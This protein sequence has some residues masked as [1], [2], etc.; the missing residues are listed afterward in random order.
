MALFLYKYI[1]S[2][3]SF[4]IS[5]L[6]LLSAC[7]S[8]GPMD[9]QER[10][11]LIA[12]NDNNAVLYRI[13]IRAKTKL[14]DAKYQSGWYPESALDA[15]FGNITKTS[16]VSARTTRKEIEDNI[17][18][19]LRH[20]H[21]K[22]IKALKDG[23]SKEILMDL[24]WRIHQTRMLPN[25]GGRALANSRVIEYNPTSSIV[26]YREGTKQVLFLSANPDKIIGVINNFAKSTDSAAAIDQLVQTIIN[27]NE[28]DLIDVQ[29]ERAVERVSELE[30]AK[31]IKVV[32]AKFDN[33][34]I[35]MTEAQGSLKALL[36]LLEARK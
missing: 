33:D 25:P 34:T 14:A 10:Y 23:D 35:L 7:S 1:S 4:I 30:L 21:K 36:A 6:F 16:E 3:K 19:G 13:T 5:L 2:V 26:T 15:V 28:Q 8:S 9:V 22:Y 32:I 18:M 17:S 11:F 24:Q 20:L 27:Q 31:D 12:E 29:I